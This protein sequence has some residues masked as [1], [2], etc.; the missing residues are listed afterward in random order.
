MICKKQNRKTLLIPEWA[1]ICSYY[2]LV[3]QHSSNVFFFYMPVPLV[4][5]CV[6]RCSCS[7]LSCEPADMGADSVSS[8][9]SSL[10][11]PPAGQ[12]DFDV[13]AQTRTGVLSA[14]APNRWEQEFADKS[15]LRPPTSHRLSLPLQLLSRKQRGHWRPSSHPGCSA[16]SCRRGECQPLSPPLA[17]MLTAV[18]RLF[19]PVQSTYWIGALC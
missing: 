16:A 19:I 4:L 5:K 17:V 8:T 2:I 15:N 1:N 11:K 6:A 18:D 10:S 3:T 13:F 12:D 9:L 14:P 7:L